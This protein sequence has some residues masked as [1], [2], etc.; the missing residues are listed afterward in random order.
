[1][2]T[3]SAQNLSDVLYSSIIVLASVIKVMFFLSTTAFLLRYML[4][5]LHA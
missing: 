5:K 1:V 4:L 3:A 2:L